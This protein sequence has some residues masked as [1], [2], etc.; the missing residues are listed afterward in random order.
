MKKIIFHLSIIIFLVSSCLHPPGKS[1]LKIKATI[2]VIQSNQSINTIKKIISNRIKIMYDTPIFMVEN[3]RKELVLF[4]PDSNDI[5][6]IKL[7]RLI[8]NSIL[9]L[10]WVDTK[11]SKPRNFRNIKKGKLKRRVVLPKDKELL[12]FIVRDEILNKL[13]TKHYIAV[14]K[15]AILTGA[16]LKSSSVYINESGNT[17][18]SFQLPSKEAEALY[19]ANMKKNIGKP[20]AII[21]DRKVLN[22]P[23]I[24]EPVHNEIQIK[25]NFTVPEAQDLAV[26]IQNPLTNVLLRLENIELIKK[27]MEKN[28]IL[29]S[30]YHS[31]KKIGYIFQKKEK[32]KLGIFMHSRFNTDNIKLFIS[33]LRKVENTPSGKITHWKK[34]HSYD[35]NVNPNSNS[36]MIRLK[37]HLFSAGTYKIA[38]F[39]NMKEIDSY[40]EYGNRFIVE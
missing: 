9:E 25:G 21:L 19:I 34:H 28:S 5:P 23:I 11:L 4:L 8:S 30:F 1:K 35:F 39:A 22:Y 17:V 2:S 38:T 10:K 13:I 33:K 15:E 14:S 18:I 27:G 32:I 36:L 37:P 7:R 26:I 24:S 29:Y 20:L 6:E 16:C 12:P 31:N 40:I 3:Q